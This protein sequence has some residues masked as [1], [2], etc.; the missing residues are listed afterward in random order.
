MAPRAL[1]SASEELLDMVCCILD[2]HDTRDSPKKT[3]KPVRDLLESGH[4][5]QS[6]SL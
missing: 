4:V 1:Y 5:A 6:E 3:E 2:F